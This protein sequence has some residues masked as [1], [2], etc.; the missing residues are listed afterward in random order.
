MCGF[1]IL[2]PVFGLVVFWLLPLPAAIAVYAIILAI[3]VYVF[4]SVRR[5]V[6]NLWD[7]KGK[8]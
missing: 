2:L 7:R 5:A 1:I 4:I 8:V 3:A 6:G